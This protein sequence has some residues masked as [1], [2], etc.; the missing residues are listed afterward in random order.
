MRDEGGTPDKPGAPPMRMLERLLMQDIR[1]RS[2]WRGGKRHGSGEICSAFRD[3][4][5][6]KAG[7]QYTKERYLAIDSAPGMNSGVTQAMI[8]ISP[9]SGNA[10]GEYA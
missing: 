7:D 2:Q 5:E 1:L 8:G 6:R 10:H 4:I 9:R 3:L